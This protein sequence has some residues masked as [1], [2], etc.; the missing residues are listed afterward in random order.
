MARPTAARDPPRR[1][2][3]AV[4]AEARQN[5]NCPSGLHELARHSHQSPRQGLF[6]PL[7]TFLRI[8]MAKGM[9]VSGAT[10][11][12]LLPEE[13]RDSGAPRVPE[14]CWQRLARVGARWGAPAA[15]SPNRSGPR[16]RGHHPNWVPRE[17]TL[18]RWLE[19]LH[20][21]GPVRAT[22]SPQARVFEE[23]LADRFASLGCRIDR[24]PHRL[25]SQRH[26]VA[27]PEYHRPTLARAVEWTSRYHRRGPLWA[28]RSGAGPPLVLLPKP[29]VKRACLYRH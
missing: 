26:R 12:T 4:P 25:M 11:W 20:A 17:G 8:S 29:R 27:A 3:L 5:R 22:G 16:I 21:F 14:C 18:E 2:R 7:A 15:A 10:L 1:R 24:G 6:R 13:I 23:W 19:Q 28:S 9:V